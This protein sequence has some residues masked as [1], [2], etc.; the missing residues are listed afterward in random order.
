MEWGCE[1]VRN[2]PG[3]ELGS[4]SAELI[5]RDSIQPPST[6]EDDL[7]ADQAHEQ[8]SVSEDRFEFVLKAIMLIRRQCYTNNYLEVLRA[9]A[10]GP[11][12]EEPRSCADPCDSRRSREINIFQDIDAD[13]SCLPICA[14]VLGF[15]DSTSLEMDD[16]IQL[17]LWSTGLW[18]AVSKLAYRPTWFWSATRVC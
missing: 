6:S 14:Y 9:R 18:I 4:L 15:K 2:N 5:S 13:I 8:S 1:A 17:E 11:S 10:A 12:E 16:G 3:K 7:M